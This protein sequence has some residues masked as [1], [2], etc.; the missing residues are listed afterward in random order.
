MKPIRPVIV[1][2]TGYTGARI[3]NELDA[4]AAVGY[5]RSPLAGRDTQCMDL[6]CAA[7][8]AKPPGGDFDVIYSIPPAADGETDVRLQR[9]LDWLEASPSRF[10][11]ISSSGVYGDRGGAL[12]DEECP[13]AP[14]NTRTRRRLAA[15][16]ALRHYA[17]GNGCVA[18][19]LRAPAIYGPDRL[20]RAR[21]QAAAPIIRESDAYPGN[22][23]HVDDLVACCIAALDETVDGGVYNVS[24]GDFRSATWFANA[25]ADMAGLPRPPQITR[26][27]AEARFSESRLSFL[28]ESRRLDNGKM[29][30]QLLPRLNYANPQDGIR[31]SLP[32]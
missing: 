8:A 4:N 3:L 16:E 30:Q 31:A 19:I 13:P 21:I 2:G 25:V 23:I 7:F 17:R 6:D 26:A 20:G 15:E 29:L 28:G 27:A 32:L 18:V 24:D 9:F 14:E 12:V 5:S 10:L 22:R 1:A 11:Y